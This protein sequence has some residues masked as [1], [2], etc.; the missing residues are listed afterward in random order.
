MIGKE[1]RSLDHHELIISFTASLFLWSGDPSVDGEHKLDRPKKEKV[2][3]K[4][5]L[6]SA[7]SAD[8]AVC[9]LTAAADLGDVISSLF[10]L[11]ACKQMK[12]NGRKSFIMS[13]PRIMSHRFFLAVI[14]R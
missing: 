5:E 3:V 6:M 9:K 13:S 8:P 7:S 14:F 1:S 12:E 4:E 11:F 10:P 2:N